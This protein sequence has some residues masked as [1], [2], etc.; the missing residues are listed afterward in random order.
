MRF[1]QSVVTDHRE[2]PDQGDG[3]QGMDVGTVQELFWG[4]V[5]RFSYGIR[6]KSAQGGYVTESQPYGIQEHKPPFVTG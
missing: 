4:W 1:I 2:N 5:Q 3:A 6:V